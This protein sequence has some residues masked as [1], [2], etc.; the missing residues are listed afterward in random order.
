[1]SNIYCVLSVTFPRQCDVSVRVVMHRH[2]AIT[3]QFESRMY[4]GHKLPVTVRS[5]IQGVRVT[6]ASL[7]IQA[8]QILRRPYVRQ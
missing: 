4:K 6:S 7:D 3:T 2:I 1:M 5:I 8:L